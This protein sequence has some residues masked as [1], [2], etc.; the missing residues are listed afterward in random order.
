MLFEVEI[1]L[2]LEVAVDGR[3]LES[4][5][6][7]LGNIDLVVGLQAEHVLGELGPLRGMVVLED[8]GKVHQ[9]VGHAL[10]VEKTQ[11]DH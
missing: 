8:V 2:A 3:K 7:D 10:L 11:M 1:P 5:K 4:G 9:W 6:L